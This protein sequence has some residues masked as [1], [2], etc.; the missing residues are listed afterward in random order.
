MRPTTTGEHVVVE[1]NAGG[2]RGFWRTDSAAFLGIPFAEPPYGD[3]R[4]LA[5]VHVKSWSGV[6]DALRYGPTPQRKALAEITTI[7]EP[8]IPGEDIL[9]LNVFTPRPHTAPGS[10]APLPVLV[11][12]HG[13]GYVAGSPASPWYDGAAFNREGVVTVTVAYRL[14]FDGFGWLPDAPGNR[15]IL[16][17]LLALEW[18]RSNISQF[19]GDPARVTIAGQSAGGGAVMTLLAMPRARGLFTAAASI[20]GVPS[21]IP[22]ERAKQTTV[23]LAERLGVAPD[24][25]SFVRVSERDLLAA[26]GTGSEPLEK[27]TA[28]D[29]IAVMRAMDGSLP[30]GSVVDGDVHPS[31]VEEGMRGGSGRDVP[32]LVG[33]TRQEFSALAQANRHLFEDHHVELLLEQVGLSPQAARRFAA[34]LQDHHPA[35]VVGQYM[36]DVMF[37]RRIVDWLDLRGEAAAPTWA[38][39]FAWPSAVSG[40][41]EHCLD[42]PFIFDLLEDPDVTRVAGPEPPQVLADHIH[43]AFVG[44]VRDQDPGWPPYRQSK[45]I[46]VFDSESGTVNG[47]YES[48]RALRS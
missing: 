39:D 3:L 41:A 37:R 23:R 15:G 28:D 7:P 16:D 5:P 4:F 12:L 44:F 47:G 40:V 9:N 35:E 25:S 27:P 31:S 6:R 21:D 11:Y 18:V 34:A 14:G 46:M 2:V 48:A 13:G 20:S 29:L 32:L 26:Q 36:T 10:E 1:T 17:W 19:G 45:S 33:S 30:L 8:S 38:Y 42:V 24:R 22:L 43:A